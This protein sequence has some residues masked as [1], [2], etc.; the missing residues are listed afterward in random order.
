M[1]GKS[2]ETVRRMI[3]SGD[4][5]AHKTGGAHG[6][7]W[8]VTLDEADA[9]HAPHEAQEP[10]T[11]PAVPPER[12]LATLEALATRTDI[13]NVIR[14]VDKTHQL[15]TERDALRA[16]VERLQQELEVERSRPWWKRR[17]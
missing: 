1:L 8:I 10:Q 2:K 14:A 5:S 12:L 15:T 6:R 17:K 4:L 13:E 3:A 9:P 16:E 11:L 7:Q